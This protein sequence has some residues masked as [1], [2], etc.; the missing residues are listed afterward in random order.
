MDVLGVLTGFFQYVA[1]LPQPIADG[2]VGISMGVIGFT[3]L[4]V[5]FKGMVISGRHYAAP[6]ALITLAWTLRWLASF[7]G[8]SV[9]EWLM[10]IFV[11]A[12][13]TGFF[14]GIYVLI[15]VLKGR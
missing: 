9:N 1:H 6:I 4:I 8:G 14:L 2:M 5:I 10:F 12:T 11:I 13:V 7:S 15:A 3:A